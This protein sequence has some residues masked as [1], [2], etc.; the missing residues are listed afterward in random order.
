MGSD[1]PKY[2]RPGVAL[3]QLA[4]ARDLLRR[5]V[6]ACRHLQVAGSALLPGIENDRGELCR[7]FALE[8][9]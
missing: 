9:C 8:A 5:V 1:L 3:G 4:A 6:S 7:H 2:L